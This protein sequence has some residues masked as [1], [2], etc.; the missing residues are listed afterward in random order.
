MIDT[1]ARGLGAYG[2][3]LLVLAFAGYVVRQVFFHP[4]SDIPGPLPAK[5]TRW[6]QAYEVW[7]GAAEKT[8]IALHEKYGEDGSL[9]SAGEG[10]GLVNH[11]STFV[12]S[13][14]RV[15]PNQVSISDPEA[16]KLI[17]GPNSRFPKV[18]CEGWLGLMNGSLMSNRP[19]CMPLGN[20][21]TTTCS[22]TEMRKNTQSTAEPSGT[23]IR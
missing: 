21:D 20:M 6:W 14:V 4:L 23:P 18:C 10:I 13:L 8:E 2:L 11:E 17:Y 1:S 5:L 19:I 9:S 15:A 16:I 22:L 7:S 12:G 3:V